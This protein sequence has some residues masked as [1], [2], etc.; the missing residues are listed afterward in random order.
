MAAPSIL[1]GR[2]GDWDIADQVR[3]RA[4]G[5][6]DVDRWGW[7]L[8]RAV[9]ELSQKAAFT[10]SLTHRPVRGPFSTLQRHVTE[11]LF[12]G[13]AENAVSIAYPLCPAMAWEQ[14]P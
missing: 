5:V 6:G 4:V 13:I 11:C 8:G 9:S 10:Y 12:S 14:R 7:F 3:A 2:G 1:P